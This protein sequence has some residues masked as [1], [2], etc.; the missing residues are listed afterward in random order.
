MTDFHN[1]TYYVDWELGSGDQAFQVDIEVKYVSPP[2]YDMA[3]GSV[4]TPYTQYKKM[5]VTVTSD[6]L[7]DEDGNLIEVKIPYLRRYYK[8]Q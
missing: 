1:N 6:Y 7:T 3:S 8:K 2:D 5:V 4:G